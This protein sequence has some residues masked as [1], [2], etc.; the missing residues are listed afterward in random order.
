MK[1]RLFGFLAFCLMGSAIQAQQTSKDFFQRGTVK[2]QLED[3]KAAIID[4]DQGIEIAHSNE[5]PKN[6]KTKDNPTYDKQLASAYLKRGLCKIKLNDKKGGCMD[7]DKAL[8]MGDEKAYREK[9]K[10]CKEY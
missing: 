6:K 8:Y 3:Y 2:Y 1:L 5:F 7:I 10:Y 9:E 4:F